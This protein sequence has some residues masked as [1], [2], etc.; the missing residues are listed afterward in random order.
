MALEVAA[1]ISISDSLSAIHPLIPRHHY[2]VPCCPSGRTVMGPPVAHN[3]I[4]CM[5][6][7]SRNR[8]Y[9]PLRLGLYLLF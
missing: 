9:V 8:T 2:V 7:P 3:A 1:P 4:E 6:P 5:C